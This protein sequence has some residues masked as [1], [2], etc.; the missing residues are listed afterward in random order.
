MVSLGPAA[1]CKGTAGSTHALNRNL[2]VVIFVGHKQPAAACRL[3][4][5]CGAQLG[6]AALCAVYTPVSADCPGITYTNSHPPLP[7]SCLLLPAC[8]DKV[9]LEHIFSS[10]AI[11]S[12]ILFWMIFYNVCHVF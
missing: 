4:S 3:C 8:R 1:V 5:S 12:Y 2:S 6:S 7:L 10:T 9:F 11:L